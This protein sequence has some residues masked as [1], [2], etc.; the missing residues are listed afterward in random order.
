MLM[1]SK[2]A[3]FCFVLYGTVLNAGIDINMADSMNW[4]DINGV[5]DYR[6][7][8]PEVIGT[9]NGINCLTQDHHG[10]L[11][12]AS[13]AKLILFDGNVWETH[14]Q[15]KDQKNEGTIIF[16]V[17]AV[18]KGRLICSTDTG[19]F[20]ITFEA[21]FQFK[22]TALVDPETNT[23][24][25]LHSLRNTLRNG[26][27]IYFYGASSVFKYDTDTRELSKIPN[28]GK[29][30][31]SIGMVENQLHY[32]SI[33]GKSIR[34]KEG[35]WQPLGRFSKS[36]AQETIR[37]NHVWADNGL[38]L[39]SD[40]GGIYQL[41]DDQIVPWPSETTQFETNR[42][43]SMEP[44]S[45][46]HLVVSIQAKGLFVLNENG[47]IIQALTREHDYRLGE[48][49][50]LLHVGGNTIWAATKDG[51]LRVRFLQ[52]LTNY[53]T[54]FPFSVNYPGILKH[55]DHLYVIGSGELSEMLTFEGGALKGF[56]RLTAGSKFTIQTAVSVEEGILCG[57][58]EETFLIKDDNSLQMI[59]SLPDISLLVKSPNNPHHVIA[60]GPD[61]FYLL[62]NE[63]GEWQLTQQSTLAPTP[64]T[65]HFSQVDA[66]G[67]TWIENGTALITKLRVING[68]IH[69][70][71]FDQSDGFQPEWINISKYGETLLFSGG[72]GDVYFTWNE[73]EYRFTPS[74]AQFLNEIYRNYP[75]VGRLC[76]DDRGNIWVPTNSSHP[77][78]RSLPNGGF[79]NDLNTLN[80]LQNETLAVMLPSKDGIV[81]IT[82]EDSIY[83]YNPAYQNKGS[84][85]RGTELVQIESAHNQFIF[86]Y[87]PNDNLPLKIPYSEN[88]LL[89]RVTTPTIN[90][91]KRVRHEYLIDGHSKEWTSLP[92]PNTLPISNFHEGKY[93]IRIRADD[94]NE[95]TDELIINLIIDPPYYRHVIA[96]VVYVFLTIA[97][98]ALIIYL[99][100]W[101][102]KRENQRLQRLVQ[103]R[104]R[105]LESANIELTQLVR[106]AESATIAKN[107]FL[108]SI[109]H[110]IR[111]PLNGIL[112]PADILLDNQEDEENN[113][114]IRMI[115]FSARNLLKLV[116]GILS[117]VENEAHSTDSG[118]TAFDLKHLLH[119][120]H[121]E[122]E[123]IA[124]E[125]DIKLR[126]KLKAGIAHFWYG[127]S[128]KIRQ[129]LRILIDNS[130]KFTDRGSIKITA[131]ADTDKKSSQLIF[132]VKD[133][134]RGIEP[135][136]R[137]RLFEPFHQGRKIDGIKN[138]G[139]G[140]GLSLFKQILDSLGGKVEVESVI[141]KG[142]KF[143]VY[144]PLKSTVSPIELSSEDIPE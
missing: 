3:G 133:T 47:K 11:L 89:I 113:E 69:A 110:E 129:S 81:W 114:L 6:Y 22:L 82:G 67:N 83:R 130:F 96:Y 38:L 8:E 29:T 116:E 68:K 65:S 144:Y 17:L 41:R 131:R 12:I 80:S 132:E 121:D 61:R 49:H 74:Q 141:N 124:K 122:F 55:R 7:F 66:F 139:T 56:R 10:R 137:K 70:E 30:L 108:Q 77:I 19:L 111:T 115:R 88:D 50:H 9:N 37:V 134:G 100:K 18:P 57:G 126:Y 44:L 125:R 2:F 31:A 97:M 63:S 84:V 112:G 91:E 73:D 87:D 99:V 75:G 85:Q 54:L 53:T 51:L 107:A 142:T 138:D 62:S 20:E 118:E 102:Y 24:T 98:L 94:G 52:P 86:P 36:A 13:G 59:A 5:P 123:A 143:T 58:I 15:T 40:G 109:T 76:K 79:K 28:E 103:F 93:H 90:S 140:I 32:F 106:K 60:C 14:Q 117:F 136:E 101:I 25:D 72:V 71:R 26:N 21:N 135:S 27:E 46:K 92:A 43:I 34:Q 4:P 128:S 120:L 48:I 95:Y 78:L 33:S 127:D 119:E 105:E 23:N 42:V 35:I 16:S 104:T 1:R 64:A 45:I 39:A